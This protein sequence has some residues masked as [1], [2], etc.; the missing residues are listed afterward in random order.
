MLIYKYFVLFLAAL[1][2]NAVCVLHNYAKHFN[3]PNPD[4]YLDEID[5]E[6]NDE[7][8]GRNIQRHVTGNAVRE[9]I[10]R[11]YFTN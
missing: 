9:T 5:L 8:Y 11:R 1:I 7:Q 2:V 4:I 6:G 3:V 10:I